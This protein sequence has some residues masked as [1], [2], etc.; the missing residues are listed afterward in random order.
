MYLSKKQR[1]MS[2]KIIFLGGVHGTG[3]GFLSEKLCSNLSLKYLSASKLIKWTEIN[4]DASNKL[5][6]NI[7][8]T[9]ERLTTALK[10]ICEEKENYLL[11]GHYCLLNSS[12]EPTKVDFD[13]FSD[14]NPVI[15]LIVKTEPEL[16]KGRLMNRD[17]KNY[18]LTLIRKML[19]FEKP[20]R[21]FGVRIQRLNAQKFS[22]FLSLRPCA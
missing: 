18:D 10:A 3:K 7:S 4:S 2:C 8:E 20:T 13:V 17:G 5:V 19:S 11:D 14:I 21:E 15:L 9:Q 1:V 22:P 16:I 6:N 12:Q